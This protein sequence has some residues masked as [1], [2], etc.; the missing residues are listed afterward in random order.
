MAHFLDIL[1]TPYIASFPIIPITPKFPCFSYVLDSLYFLFILN[2]LDISV[3][4]DRAQIV[5]IPYLSLI[6]QVLYRHRHNHIPYNTNT[7]I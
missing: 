7:S 2:D 3:S 6:V 1:N 5:I 4:L